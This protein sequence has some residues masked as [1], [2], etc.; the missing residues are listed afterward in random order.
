[1]SEANVE[2]VR[3]QWEAFERGDIDGFFA[4]AAEDVEFEED[5]AFPE[6]GT[7]RGRD[8]IVGYLVSFQEQMTDHRFEVEELRD[9]GD[10]RVLALMHETARGTTSGADVDQHPAF[11]YEFRD[12]LIVRTRA[13]LYRTDAFAALGLDG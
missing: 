6:A 3:R 12:G 5:P 10:G 8:E 7:Y 11:L 9:V 1:M 13:Y 4:D 2:A